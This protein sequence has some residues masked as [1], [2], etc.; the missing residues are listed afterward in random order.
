MKIAV[1]TPYR[2]ED[3]G[4]LTRC[5]KSVLNQTYTNFVHVMVADGNPHPMI[6]KW[7]DNE[8]IILPQ[9][10]DDAGAT[11]RAIA[12]ISAF[13]R[14]YDA[15]SFLDADNTYQLNHL[16][17]MVSTIGQNDVV[18]ATRNICSTQGN[19]LYTD[20]IESDG[21]LFCDTN[22]LFLKKSTIHLMTHWVTDPSF[23]LWSDRQFWSSIINS[24]C[25]RVHCSEPTVNY[26]SRWAWHYQQAGLVPPADSVWIDSLANG[27][28]VHKKHLDVI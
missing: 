11:P 20:V 22:C 10:H 17:T 2:N 24:N 25:K 9:A 3:A 4:I 21:N 5:H 7:L 16:E 1:I 27:T 23:K 12:A 13:S 18:S 15:V 19:F 8:H 26:H 28:L 14:G 6:N